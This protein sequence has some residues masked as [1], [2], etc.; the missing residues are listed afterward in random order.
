MLGATCGRGS[1]LARKDVCVSERAFWSEIQPWHRCRY[2]VSIQYP[3]GG[4]PNEPVHPEVL[5]A[6]ED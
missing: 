5:D 6:S 1:R 3:Y 2:C 4:A